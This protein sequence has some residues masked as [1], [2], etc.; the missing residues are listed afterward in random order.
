MRRFAARHLGMALYLAM[1][2]L[3][4]LVLY[5]GLEQHLFAAPRPGMD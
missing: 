4:A 2:A 3:G 5:R 1:F